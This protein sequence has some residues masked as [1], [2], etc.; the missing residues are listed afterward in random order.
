MIDNP[1]SRTVTQGTIFSCALAEDYPNVPVLGIV[2][3]A[4]CD[5]AH[6]K[7]EIFSYIPL[8]RFEDW[9]LQDGRRILAARSIAEATG[10]MKSAIK[11]AGLSTS[12]LQTLSFEA[13][14][15]ELRNNDDK[16]GQKIANRFNEAYALFQTAKKAAEVVLPNPDAQKFIS[17]LKK[18]YSTLVKE[19]LSNSLAEF[20]Y[21]DRSERGEICNGYVALL[22]EIRFMPSF[23]AKA[24]VDGIDV[25]RFS[26]LCSINPRLRD[27]LAITSEDHYAL[28]V[29]LLK[30]PF[31]EH[32]MQRLTQLFSR[33]GV[34]EFPP[35]KL[36][37][38]CEIVPFKLEADR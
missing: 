6:E 13:I 37:A 28:P 29:G 31:T 22:R 18:L 24:L 26:E 2:I 10:K 32:V 3:T 35:D 30:S 17:Q 36:R 23:G 15:A 16:A 25:E 1:P 33:I 8:I 7:A 12:I 27:K 20:H 14:A 9:L 21:I 19:L 4:R 11:D 5:I 34:T 38:M